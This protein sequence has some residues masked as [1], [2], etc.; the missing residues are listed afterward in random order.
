MDV[1][2]LGTGSG[3][4]AIAAAK[5]GAHTVQAVDVDEVAVAS[6]QE[7]VEA[8]D[9]SDVVSVE[10]GSLDKAAGKYD[11]I[12]VNILSKV[13]RALLERGLADRLKP[14]GTVIASGII[15]EQEHEVRAAFVQ[16]GIE[17]VGRYTERDW[18]ALIGRQDATPLFRTAGIDLP[19]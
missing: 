10:V 1:L 14:G 17:I 7:N 13:I 15:D 3:V 2:D 18:V 4:L 5:Q 16:H 6:A 9:V 19:E 12:L 8:N 11:L